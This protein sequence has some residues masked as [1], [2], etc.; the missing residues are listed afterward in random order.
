MTLSGTVT[1]LVGRDVVA[2][3]DPG[4]ADGDHLD[5]LTAAVGDAALVCILITHDH[6]DHAG[7]A[8]ELSSRLSARLGAPV[9]SGAAGTLRDGASIPTDHGQLV[10]LQ[11]PGHAPDHMAFHW[12]TAN[13][14]FCGDL[15]MGGLD[16]AVVAAPEGN[17]R[18]YLASLQRLRDLR[19]EIIY[20]A[21]G[22]PFTDPDA[23]IER[24]LVH[25]RRREQQVI[26]AIAAGARDLDEITG[27]VY[28]AGLDPRLRDFARAAVQAYLAHLR[29]TGRLSTGET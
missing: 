3:I 9:L 22:P 4:S 1:W 20:P 5:A 26:D 28:G 25:R 7:G 2:V 6:P 17:L 21:H 16:T 14:I 11:T 15:M 29:E 23:D 27:R 13:A 18:E 24:Y 10:A 12:P 19:P 8:A